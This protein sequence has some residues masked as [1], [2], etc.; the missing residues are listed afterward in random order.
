MKFTNEQLKLLQNF[1]EQNLVDGKK[2]FRHAVFA[3]VKNNF[4]DWKEMDFVASLSAAVSSG[5]LVG[6]ESQRGPY[7]GIKRAFKAPSTGPLTTVQAPPKPEPEEVPE[8]KTTQQIISS[9]IENSSPAVESEVSRPNNS[10]L[11]LNGRKFK[12][13][14]SVGK[15]RDLLLRVIEAKEDNEG[16]VEYNGTKYAC[17]DEQAAYLDRFLFYTYGAHL[18]A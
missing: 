12:V 5:K 8:A 15:V 7:G 18:E 3:E 16:N 9:V 1:L 13:P 14:E 10:E 11:H 2:M 6:F 4:S 17:T